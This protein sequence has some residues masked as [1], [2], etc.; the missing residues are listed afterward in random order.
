M[1]LVALV[2][3]TTM[4]VHDVPFLEDLE[5]EESVLS[6]QETATVP[7]GLFAALTTPEPQQD[8]M[9]QSVTAVPIP[10][11]EVVTGGFDVVNREQLM[12][13]GN[14]VQSPAARACV[15]RGP[16]VCKLLKQKCVKHGPVCGYKKMCVRRANTCIK[17]GKCA[18]S[19]KR[20]H[21]TFSKKCI[22]C[23]K[24]TKICWHAHS[25]ATTCVKT[26]A[27]KCFKDAGCERRCAQGCLKRYQG[28]IRRCKQECTPCKKGT[29]EK[30][31]NA[32]YE[33]KTCKNPKKVCH[34]VDQCIKRGKSCSFKKTC[35][36]WGKACSK[37]KKCVQATKKCTSKS[38]CVRRD[39]RC[40]HPRLPAC[41]ACRGKVKA[42]LG[43]DRVKKRCS[44]DCTKK[45]GKA[46]SK[47]AN[48]CRKSCFAGCRKTEAVLKGYCVQKCP[49]CT[50]RSPSCHL[51]CV[52]KQTTKHCKKL[53]KKTKMVPTCKKVCKKKQVQRHCIVLA[54]S[55]KPHRSATRHVPSG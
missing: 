53:C 50:H 44:R 41:K 37:K 49:I 20:C 3:V 30:C 36:K 19:G 42:C 28:Y 11:Q 24:K 55:G 9:V 27:T 2:A 35:V 29:S 51:K 39:S 40:S 31:W 47:F 25:V 6:A 18:Q 54:P 46:Q 38:K 12:S 43:Y 17:H 52:K 14:G 21:Y 8:A 5:E 48:T 23:A 34:R 4:V 1:A 15:R 22:A 33:W 45:C 26:C 10:A 16:P 7:G 32:C 13:A